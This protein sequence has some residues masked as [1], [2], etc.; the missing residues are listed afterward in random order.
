M[1][2]PIEKRY[3]KK[4]LQDENEKNTNKPYSDKNIHKKC[5][6][7]IAYP[8]N[9]LSKWHLIEI[10]QSCIGVRESSWNTYSTGDGSALQT[11]NC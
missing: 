6:T 2:F 11:Q 1:C 10:T 9:F 7:A 8:L 4:N 5:I 3:K